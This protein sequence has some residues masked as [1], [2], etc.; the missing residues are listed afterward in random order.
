M[1]ASPVSGPPPVFPTDPRM[2][3]FASQQTAPRPVA[4]EHVESESAPSQAAAAPEN[5]PEQ[6]TVRRMPDHVRRDLHHRLIGSLDLSRLGSRSDEELRQ[7]IR[8]AAEDISR[9]SNQLLSNA[10]R[11]SLVN[12]VMDETF[13]L[14]PLEQLLRDPSISDILINGPDVIFCERKGRLQQSHV[15]FSSEDH[16]LQIMDLL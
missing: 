7:E 14:G 5:D 10:E 8:K 3:A 2:A 12:E 11:D 16:L 9:Q 6:P 13:G 1:T 4:F 15:K